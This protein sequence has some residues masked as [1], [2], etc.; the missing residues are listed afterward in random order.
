MKMVCS[1]CGGPHSTEDCPLTTHQK[2]AT[3]TEQMPFK[4]LYIELSVL[5]PEEKTTH[6]IDRGNDWKLIIKHE[7][8]FY[9]V[10]LNSEDLSHLHL[11]AG[12]ITRGE[13]L[14]I[15]GEYF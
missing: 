3:A 5:A 8:K 1:R 7:D 6:D 11:F 4:R 10:K 9:T 13:N 2:V 14:P 15:T 12:K